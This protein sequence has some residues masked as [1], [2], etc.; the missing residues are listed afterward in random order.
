MIIIVIARHLV[1]DHT[2]I[3]Q[4]HKLFENLE[5]SQHKCNF[6]GCGWVDAYEHV[7]QYFTGKNDKTSQQ[8]VITAKGQNGKAVKFLVTEVF[9]DFVRNAEELSKIERGIS[10]PLQQYQALTLLLRGNYKDYTKADAQ[11]KFDG[12]N[13]AKFDEL[14]VLSLHLLWNKLAECNILSLY[15]DS[16]SEKR[17]EETTLDLDMQH[18][19]NYIITAFQNNNIPSMLHCS[20]EKRLVQ[21]QIDKFERFHKAYYKQTTYADA[22]LNNPERQALLTTQRLFY[23]DMILNKIELAKW[24]LNEMWGSNAMQKS[25]NDANVD[26][27]IKEKLAGL[28]IEMLRCATSWLIFA[29]HYS[30]EMKR[31]DDKPK[32]QAQNRLPTPMKPIKPIQRNTESTTQKSRKNN[33]KAQQA[34]NSADNKEKKMHIKPLE[35]NEYEVKIERLKYLRQQEN[36]KSA[37]LS[38]EETEELSELQEYM[39]EHDRELQRSEQAKNADNK[40]KKQDLTR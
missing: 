32:K 2:K 13:H 10:L 21:M 39:Q 9:G 26:A 38:W 11:A 37:V 16:D 23:V 17:L 25:A 4:P 5:G 8:K 33:K 28:S 7:L 15:I 36:S 12:L 14:R 30:A 34:P 24:S 3:T 22:G 40:V 29:R 6:L 35:M 27:S 1:N 19:C 20:L 31:I 18:K